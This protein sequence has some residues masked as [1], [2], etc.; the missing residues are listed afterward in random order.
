[1]NAWFEM[2]GRMSTRDRMAVQVLGSF[3]AV[4]LL[5][6]V[7]VLPLLHL[8]QRSLQALQRSEQLNDYFLRHQEQLQVAAQHAQAGQVALPQV[9]QNAMN[10]T[11]LSAP[12][13]LSQN[14]D[15]VQADF[16]A[17]MFNS[18]MAW[19]SQLELQGIRVVQ[20]DIHRIPDNPGL[21]N[22]SVSLTAHR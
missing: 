12:A 18:L 10:L 20:L 7:L 5:I 6:E 11:G 9:I 22:V 16:K 17:V 13:S 19:V 8:H 14:G 21:V 3:L 1:M 4:F 2:Y 15:Q